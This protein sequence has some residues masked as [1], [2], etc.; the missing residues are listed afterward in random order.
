MRSVTTGWTEFSHLIHDMVTDLILQT[1][2]APV[3]TDL[4]LQTFYAPVVTDL[5]LPLLLNAVCLAMKKKPPV[6]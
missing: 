2:Y 3:V 6:L 1:F 4:I 5:I